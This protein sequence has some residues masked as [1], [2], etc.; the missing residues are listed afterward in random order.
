MEKMIK[1]F[2]KDI[3]RIADGIERLIQDNVETNKQ[4]AGL[5]ETALEKIETQEKANAC[6]NTVPQMPT[7]ETPANVMPQMPVME[8][9]TNAI[10][11]SN[12]VETYTQEQ[13]AVAMGRALDAG[14]MAEIQTILSIFGVSSLM[15]IP[16][17]KYN[18]LALRLKEIG[19]DV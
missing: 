13:M 10:P 6:E 11:V 3:H 16:Q 14:K 2:F 19:V 9:P 17:D 1:E 8:V 5:C 7:M 12:V 15:E 4:V 18:D